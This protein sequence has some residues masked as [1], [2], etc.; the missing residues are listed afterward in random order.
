MKF[1]NNGTPMRIRTYTRGYETTNARGDLP[2]YE[3][4]LTNLTFCR[5]ID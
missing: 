4:R 3:E 5:N 1:D 2:Y